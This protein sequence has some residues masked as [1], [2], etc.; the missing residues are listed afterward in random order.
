LTIIADDGD[1]EDRSVVPVY[2]RSTDGSS[3]KLN[4]AMDN[5]WD[6]FYAGQK[7]KSQYNSMV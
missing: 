6:G 7:H 5:T 1:W 4:A 2:V 3:N